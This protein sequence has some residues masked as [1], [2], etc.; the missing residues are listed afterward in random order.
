MISLV[1]MYDLHSCGVTLPHHH[2]QSY[3]LVNQG[4]VQSSTVTHTHSHI[5]LARWHNLTYSIFQNP[6]T[7]SSVSQLISQTCFPHAAS[8]Q[9]A[10]TFSVS[11]AKHF[12]FISMA[13]LYLLM[14]QTTFAFTFPQE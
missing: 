2:L 14:L 11:P 13:K 10:R 8:P 7:G 6:N 1:L 12:M 9:S 4:C 5:K 3:W